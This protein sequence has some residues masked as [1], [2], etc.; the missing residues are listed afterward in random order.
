M[1]AK[2]NWNEVNWQEQDITIS[3]QLG[4]T[5]EGVRQKRKRLHIGRSLFYHKRNASILKKILNLNTE[6]MT[7]PEIALVVK[8]STF[9][10][11]GILK[12]YKKPFIFIDK[13]KGGKYEWG[14]AD[15]DQTDKEVAVQLGVPN[16]GTVTQHRRRLGII[17]HRIKITEAKKERIDWL[18]PVEAQ[19]EKVNI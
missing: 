2:Y 13:R 5:R 9:Y 16:P 3:K 4:C 19:E 11:K 12:E 10:A 7:L 15:W 14:K 8:C 6:K 17:K 1:K 18:V